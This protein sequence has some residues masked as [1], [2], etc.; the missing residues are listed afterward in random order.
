MKNIR[1]I[2]KAL[3]ADDVSELRNSFY[4]DNDKVALLLEML[5]EEVTD[6][7]IREKLGLSTNAYSTLRSR[8]HTKVQN[9]L[10]ALSD[11][12]RADVLNKLLSIDDIIFTQQPTIALTTLKKLERE[13][14]R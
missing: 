6:E 11:S 5:L 10:I 14:I 12:P 8:L 13:L 9:H 1:I 2:V 4:R 7:E 3:S